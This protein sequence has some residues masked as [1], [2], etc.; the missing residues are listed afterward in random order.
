MFVMSGV[1]LALLVMNAVFVLLHIHSVGEIKSKLVVLSA[2]VA[3]A[4]VFC[5]ARLSSGRRLVWGFAVA[6]NLIQVSSLL[7]IPLI[8][9]NLIILLGRNVRQSFAKESWVTPAN[10]E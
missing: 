2:V 9:V 8:A 3:I 5:A 4:Q 7:F 10:K 6:L 1:I